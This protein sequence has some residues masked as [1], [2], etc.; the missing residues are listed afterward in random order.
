M[1]VRQIVALLTGA[2]DGCPPDILRP[3]KVVC[4]NAPK[5]QILP[6]TLQEKELHLFNGDI[7]Y[8]FQRFAADLFVA[9]HLPGNGCA[10]PG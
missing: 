6:Q 3:A 10:Y 4:G 7:Q 5:V 2:Q 1:V 8:V 9:H